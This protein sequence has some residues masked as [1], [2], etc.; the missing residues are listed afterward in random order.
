MARCTQSFGVAALLLVA[1]G[2]LGAQDDA[3]RAV[4]AGLAIQGRIARL[5]EELGLP[6]PLQIRVGIESGEAATGTG[7]EHAQSQQQDR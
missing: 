4:R 2:T 5:C 6:E 7:P 3:L 1:S